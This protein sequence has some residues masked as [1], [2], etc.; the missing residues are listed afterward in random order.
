MGRRPRKSR[1]E[2][3]VLDDP[4]TVYITSVPSVTLAELAE[5]FKGR[6]GCSISNLTKRSTDEG[7]R[8][9]RKEYQARLKQLALDEIAKDK[10]VVVARANER[11]IQ[12]GEQMEKVSRMGLGAAARRLRQII[13]ENEDVDDRIMLQILRASSQ[14]GKTGVDVNRKGLGLADQ[15]VYIRNVRE[16]VVRIIRTLENVLGAH[17]DLLAVC[18]SEIQQELLKAEEEVADNW[19]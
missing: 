5:M 12:F 19:E 11:H 8:R 6:R 17:P 7:W 1:P 16:I 3:D 13:D 4:L 10:A 14:L 15:I 9:K 18:R 2:V